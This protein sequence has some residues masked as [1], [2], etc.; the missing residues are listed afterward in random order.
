VNSLRENMPSDDGYRS[1]T[2]ICGV[3]LLPNSHASSLPVP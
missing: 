2:G 1:H 3:M